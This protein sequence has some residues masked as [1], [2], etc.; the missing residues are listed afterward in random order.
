MTGL[1]LA[2]LHVQPLAG[3]PIN[4]AIA[5]SSVVEITATV[6]ADP[7]RS[8]VT[9]GLDLSTR[10]FGLVKLKTKTISFHGQLFKTRVPITA[11]VNGDE[12][13]KLKTLPIGTTL[14][15]DGKF[16]A[17]EYSRGI[18]ASVN[19]L[20][21][22]RVEASPPRFQYLAS[23]F[24]SG[25]HNALAGTDQRVAG[26]VPGLALG[27]T[28]NSTDEL[29]AEMKASGL[30]H[31]TAVSG[32]NVTML[33]AIILALGR[34][35]K[36]KHSTNYILAVLGLAAFVIIVRPQPSVIRATAM[37]LVMVYA[38]FSRSQKSPLPALTASVIALIAID[39]WLAISYGFALSVG[40][41]AGLLLLA[42]NLLSTFD[43][44]LPKRIPEWLV[45]GLVVTICAQVA[46]FPILVGL[47]SAVSLASLPA[48]LISVP[49]SGPTMVLGLVA[50]LL[51]PIAFPLAKLI[52]VIATVPAWGIVW[53]AQFFANQKL[54][55]IPWPHGAGGVLLALGAVVAGIHL[56]L[57]WR[58]LTRVQRNSA[59]VTWVI[60]ISFLWFRPAE[61]LIKWVPSD[62]QIVSC[63]VGQGDAT[64]IK[65][66]I[67]EAIVVD[68]GGNPD[69]IDRCL[70]DLGIKKIPLLLLTHFHADH[71]V[72]LPGALNRREVGQI[73][74]S[75]LAD[76]PLTTKFV[77]G[78]LADKSMTAQVMSYP[79]YLKLGVV[80]LFC[81]WP[82]QTAAQS[83]SSN[84][85]SVSL[86][87]RAGETNSLTLLLPGDI[88]QPAQD[89]I[90]S[91]IGNLKVDVI[92]VPHHGSR[93]QS[94]EFAQQSYAKL[95]LVSAGRDNNYG[96]PAPETVFLYE[97]IGAKVIRTDEH[98]SIAVQKAGNSLIVKSQK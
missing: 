7:Q 20:G 41:T 63:D 91:K 22:V 45:L 3:S 15:F 40:A 67:H 51:A 24:R 92:K 37:G 31:L 52:A 65:V 10:D 55:V 19:V 66:S 14:I 44:H 64:V 4:K 25:L 84:N 32:S 39:P 2:V 79:E 59:L 8:K 12:F 42:K 56:R 95:A 75:P 72:G 96:H 21:E 76:P 70:T 82:E 27:D 57:N 49:L 5:Q 88:E 60:C 46:V 89:Q 50:A 9:S 73:R 62:W 53:C 93:N 77:Y 34:K 81:I 80:E 85:A 33:I 98:G 74:I 58:T 43:Q 87:I 11:F 28:S 90:V 48:N 36:F 94:T 69:L 29:N 6:T 38:L 68:V 71:V 26:L 13:L 78:V 35:L 17:G 47:N 97:S 86:L 23:K 30:T 1:L 61:K 16:K 83:M 54:L 18:A